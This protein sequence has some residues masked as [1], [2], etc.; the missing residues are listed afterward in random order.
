MIHWSQAEALIDR[1]TQEHGRIDGVANCVGSVLLKS[2]HTT[3]DA[4][5]DKVYDMMRLRFWNSSCNTGTA[6]HLSITGSSSKQS[7]SAVP[8][9]GTCM[10]QL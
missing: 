8:K 4:D 7:C 5:F 2:A 6:G 3:S 9:T 10:R 1:V